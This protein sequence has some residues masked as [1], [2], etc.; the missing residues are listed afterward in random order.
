MTLEPGD[1]ITF[2]VKGTRKLYR[3]TLEACSWLAI[4]AEARQ[5]AR[6]AAMAKAERRRGRT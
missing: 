3:T 4:R 1:S 2:R 6:V 5:Q